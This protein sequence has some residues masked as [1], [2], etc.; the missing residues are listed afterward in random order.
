MPTKKHPG[1]TRGILNLFWYILRNN[2]EYQK[3][4]KDYFKNPNFDKEHKF[5]KKW[6]VEDL[7]D[8][9]REYDD[10]LAHFINVIDR[11]NHAVSEGLSYYEL[12]KGII[13]LEVNLRFSNKRILE[14]VESAVKKSKALY[15]KNNA[16][17]PP[18]KTLFGE[19]REESDEYYENIIFAHRLRKEKL[20]YSQI[21]KKAKAEK[22]TGFNSIDNVRNYL[23]RFDDLKKK[24]PVPK[25]RGK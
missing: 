16:A 13:S 8:P 23:K 17:A 12:E 5:Y 1:K 3:D 7:L 6:G 14:E 11:P 21:L 20:T 18:L 25:K 10:C 4:Y 15:K 2:N 9:A 22:R 19:V 24:L